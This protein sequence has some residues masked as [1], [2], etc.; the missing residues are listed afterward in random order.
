MV[1]R[2]A[3]LDRCLQRHWIH[4]APAAQ[5]DEVR[6]GAADRQPLR[7]LLVAGMRHL[8][9][10]DGEAVFLRQ[11]LIDRDRLLAIGRAVIEDDDLLTL[12]L[13]DAAFLGGDVVHDARRLAVGVEQQREDIR[14]DPSVGGVGAA[15]V[16]RD[17]RYLVGGDAI[18]HGVGDADRKRIPGGRTRMALLPLVAFDAALDLILRLAFVPG[19]LDAVDAAIADVDQ[20]EIVDEAAEEAGAAGRIG[21]DAIALKREI[22]LVGAGGR[23]GHRHGQRRRDGDRLDC[24]EERHG[25]GTPGRGQTWIGPGS[26]SDV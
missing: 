2:I 18:D 6:L 20:V 14:E 7:L 1:D 12:Q 23:Q 8:D 16:D 19:Q 15:V 25:R 9:L 22:L 13:V 5:H 21:S 24:A 26:F 4:H 11:E 3:D 17:Q 10:L